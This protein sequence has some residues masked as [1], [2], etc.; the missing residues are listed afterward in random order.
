[1]AG[2]NEN[3][4]ALQDK[5]DAIA[6]Q[7]EALSNQ[8]KGLDMAI[9]V[10][11]GQGQDAIPTIKIK[12]PRGKNVKETVLQLVENSGAS[13]I[14]AIGVVETAKNMSIHLERASVS[15]LLS[16]LKK[17]GVLGIAEGRYFIPKATSM[18]IAH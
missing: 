3:M 7:I 6:A 13:G 12:P 14:N 11:S 16:R 10:V 8:L 5:R 17:E 2:K 1:M 9:A 18:P 4:R 15:S